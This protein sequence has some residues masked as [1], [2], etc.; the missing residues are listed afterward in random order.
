MKINAL[1]LVTGLMAFSLLPLRAADDGSEI[2]PVIPRFSVNYMDTSIDPRV[3]FAGYAWGNWT[4]NNPIP[5]DKARWG[6]FDELD[7][8]N[9]AALKGI[10]ESVA[11]RTQAPGSIEQKVGDFY[12]SAMDTKAIDA[13][14]IKPISADRA[15][16]SSTVPCDAAQERSSQGPPVGYS[17]RL[18]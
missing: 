15:T 16:E 17:S 5:G 13:A 8:F 10:L 9:Q 7:Q 11:A 6:S 12:T 1:R 18:P 3:D 2:K 14:G 4:K